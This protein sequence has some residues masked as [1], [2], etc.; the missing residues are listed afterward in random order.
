MSSFDFDYWH[1]KIIYDLSG[2]IVAFL[3][4]WFF[5]KKV[6]SK[7]ELPNPFKSKDQKMEYYL[8]VIAW[9]MFGG[10]IISTFDGAMIPG[11][12]PEWGMLISKSIAWALFWG[13]ITAEAY[14]YL[15]HIKTPTGI[16]FL[17]GIVLGVLV[18]RIGAI[19]T[20]LRDFTYGLP[21]SLPW[22][23]DF[24]DGITRHPT[25]IYEMILL[26]LFFI[27]FCFW[28]YSHHR[29]WWINNWFY[30]FIII[31]FVYRFSVGFIQPYSIWWHWLSTYQV[32]AIP[33]V[34]YGCWMLRKQ[35]F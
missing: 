22:W 35:Y 23:V 17:P 33:M 11:R 6:L 8:Y 32:I 13:I 19:M 27:I 29:K 24:W 28:L 7:D 25:M 16:L 14:K 31:Y 15:N 34:M 18:G 3:V 21:T 5:Y 2:Y 4:T 12:N 10:M 20:G 26:G 30:V 1:I 9:A